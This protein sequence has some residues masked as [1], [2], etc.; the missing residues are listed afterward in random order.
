MLKRNMIFLA[1]CYGH[2]CR[3]SSRDGSVS[4]TASLVT[5]TP[6]TARVHLKSG[7]WGVFAPGHGVVLAPMFSAA[8]GLSVPARVRCRED[9]CLHL[10]FD[11]ALPLTGF[12][13]VRLSRSR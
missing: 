1:H 11:Q 3:L 10:C 9:D 6:D 13:L 7:L 5:I 8:P 12:E 2:V 4:G